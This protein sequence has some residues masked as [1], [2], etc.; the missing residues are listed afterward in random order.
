MKFMDVHDGMKGITKEQLAAEHDKDLK[1]QT[2]EKGVKFLK[3]WADP[4]TGKVFCLSEGP[5]R[6]AVARVHEKAGHPTHQIY[7]VDVEV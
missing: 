3:A 4:K 7:E 6:A 2:S 5:D 1:A